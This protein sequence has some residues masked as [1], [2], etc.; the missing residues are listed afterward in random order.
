MLSN[1]GHVSRNG[2][3]YRVHDATKLACRFTLTVLNMF[4]PAWR[5]PIRLCRYPERPHEPWITRL[6]IRNPSTGY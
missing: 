6:R 1:P 4:R 3:P 5:R 2:Y